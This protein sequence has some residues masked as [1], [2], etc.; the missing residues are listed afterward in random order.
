[1]RRRREGRSAPLL[2]VDRAELRD[3]LAARG[4]PFREDST[5]ADVAIPRN[6]I[7]HELIPYLESH[8]SPGVTDVLAREAALARQDEDFLH[9]EAIKLAARI[10]L[11]DVTVR[12]GRCRGSAARR[13]R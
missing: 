3:Y 1:M 7:R 12:I 6:R 11:T 4:E 9:G 5:N 13:A 10:V 2:D 8:F